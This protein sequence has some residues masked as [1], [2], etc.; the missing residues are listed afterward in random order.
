MKK[1]AIGMDSGAFNTKAISDVGQ[2]VFNTKYSEGYTDEGLLDEGTFNVSIDGKP[3]T[4][5]NKAEYMDTREGKDS[6][7]HILCTLT[8]IAKLKGDA[9]QIYLGY[10]ESFNRYVNANQKEKIKNKLEGKHIVEFLNEGELE[11]HEFEIVLV[12]ILPEGLG[13]I[14]SN[15]KSNLG[16]KYVIDWGGST[17]NYLEVLNGKPTENSKSFT[18]GSYNIFALAGDAISKKG[19]GNFTRNQI[20]LWVEN[21]CPNQN[22]QTVIDTTIQKQLRKIDDSLMPF[23]INLHDLIEV[24]FTGGTSSL[25]NSQ[26]KAYYKSAK[27]VDEP[28]MSNV[29]GFHEYMRLKYSKQIEE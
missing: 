15:L 8:A 18:L 2:L 22:I 23:G 6:E 10:G 12:H 14:L 16:L 7:V 20:K 3:Y 28:L 11:T 25:F 29:K 4:I 9:E 26:I 19:L 5:G 21:R 24:D 13:H 27:M 17:M 1:K